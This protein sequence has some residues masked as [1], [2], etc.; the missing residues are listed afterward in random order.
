MNYT[1]FTS[2]RM[3]AVSSFAKSGRRRNF[4]SHDAIGI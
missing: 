4:E 2:S 1:H 3:M